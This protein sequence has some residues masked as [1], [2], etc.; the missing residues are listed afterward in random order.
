MAERLD[1]QNNKRPKDIYF[2]FLQ[3][4]IHSTCQ[5]S[6]MFVLVDWFIIDTS[7]TQTELKKKEKSDH[8]IDRCHVTRYSFNPLNY[9]MPACTFFVILINI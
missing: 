3:K 2:Y 6:D 9:P 5:V 8:L 4:S 1:S 7:L